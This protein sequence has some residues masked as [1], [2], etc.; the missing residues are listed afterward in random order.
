LVGTRQIPSS[1]PST[2][3]PLSEGVITAL[4]ELRRRGKG[5][6]ALY[7]DARRNGLDVTVC[8]VREY[9]RTEVDE[10][11]REQLH[12]EMPYKGMSAAEAPD[13]RWQ[14]DLALYSRKEDGNI[15]FLLVVDVFTRLLDAEP[16]ASKTATAVQRAFRPI[17]QRY[18]DENPELPD[19]LNGLI[20]TTDRGPEFQGAF[21]EY[22][23]NAGG[24]WR[25]RPVGS[26]NDIAVLDRAM[27][28]LKKELKMATIDAGTTSWVPFLREAVDNWNE[29]Y[30]EP[31]H[32]S[33]MD[34]VQH[35]E[36]Q[37]RAQ[38]PE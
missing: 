11:G 7:V 2:N 25:T 22:I 13:S 10:Q 20:L 15:G 19:P 4:D 33:P 18:K 31:L 38:P 35:P 28:Q 30:S 36:T 26:K 9:F 5:P 1:Q 12:Q 29:S 17:V 3:M 16:I 34:V 21:R 27:G 14:A 37:V 6:K 23:T 32:G 24:V 8:D